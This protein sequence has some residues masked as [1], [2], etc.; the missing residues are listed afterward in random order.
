MPSNAYHLATGALLALLS[1][2]APA[3]AKAQAA[4]TGHASPVPS[5]AAARRTEPISVDGRLDEAA[6][7]AAQP[8]TDFVQYE[9]REMEPATQRTEVRFLFDDEALYVGARMYDS[10]GAAGVVTRLVRRDG[11]Y[12]SDHL[13]LILDTY[14]DHLG[15]AQ[16]LVN[17]S[18]VKGDNLSGDESWD[19][20]WQTNA[21]IDSLGWTAEMRIPFSQLRFART[22]QQTWGLQVGRQVNRLNE[23]SHWSAWRQNENGGPS[24]FGH[25][26]GIEVGSGSAGS[27]EIVPYVLAQSTN[28]APGDEENPF[29]RS[30]EQNYRMGLDLKHR[31]T[32][33]LTLSATFNPDFGQVEV[34]PA[35]VNLSVFET[36]FQEKRPF[37]VEGQGYFGFSPFWCHFCSNSSNLGLFYSRRIGR[38]PQGGGL[39][40]DRSEFASVPDNTTILGAAK[41]TGRTQKGWSVAMLNA[42][43]GREKA[44]LI[45]EDGSRGDMVVEPLTNY[46]VTR[47]KRDMRGGNLVMGGMATS[48]YRDLGNTLLADR[49]T[50]HAE[51]VGYDA[52]AWW[53]Q[54]TY[55]L[56]FGAAISQVSGDTAAIRRI[57]HSSARYF[58]RP[59]RGNGS[60]GFFSDAYDPTLTGL[61]GYGVYSRFAKDAG[62]WRWELAGNARSPGFEVNDIAFL[63]RTDYLWMNANVARGWTT[64]TKYY[65]RAEVLVG[66]Q[67]QYNYD[68]DR[69]DR[70]ARISLYGQLPNYWDIGAFSI[71]RPAFFD[72]RLTRGGPVMLREG[73]W[74]NQLNIG[75]DSRKALSFNA[76]PSYGPHAFGAD[77]SLNL[78]ARYRP[79]SNVSISLGPRYDLTSTGYQYVTAKEDPTATAF[80]GKRY[81]FANLEQRT[82]AMDT[83]LNVT[84]TPDLSL[85]LFAQPFI[86]SGSYTDFKQYDAPRRLGMSVYGKDVG[87][88]QARGAGDDREFEVDPDGAGPAASFTFDDP[89]FNFRSLRGNAVLRW[90]YRP[91]ST[92]FLVWTQNRSDNDSFGDLRFDRDRRALFNAAA[93]NVFLIKMNY[94]LSR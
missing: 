87:T 21:Q 80:F 2:T 66:A 34:D 50:S 27:T 90:E 23:F 75:T 37:F 5:A 73:W 61:R 77:W 83:R 6:W 24:R 41:V 25:L 43:A 70:Q 63:T 89:N 48:T 64:P 26:T 84:F 56:L 38:V 76:N 60:N 18:G 46:F 13:M 17:P 72:E 33:N 47:V 53:K 39:A 15:S 8:V 44:Q 9:P 86:S 32:S 91:G 69:T 10:L 22:T 31:L 59:D 88:L 40:D 16:F 14:H 93:N 68:G 29:F 65:R 92:L 58:Q 1:M 71:W 3:G 19:P 4:S 49:L 28:R 81:V 52:E 51:A 62:D 54:R 74:Y 36:G 42:V 7:G 94:W 12:D 20:V 78:N 82:L 35:V 55:H 45:M 67:Q 85:E 30:H 79:A 11:Q 57:Q